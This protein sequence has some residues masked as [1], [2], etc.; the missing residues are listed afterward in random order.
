MTYYDNDN[1]DAELSGDTVTGF[2]IEEHKTPTGKETNHQ[3][4]KI[5]FSLSDLKKKKL[6]N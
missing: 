2:R 1:I 5:Q 6:Q 4:E 3:I